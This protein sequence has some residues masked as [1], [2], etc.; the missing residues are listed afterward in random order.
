[1]WTWRRFEGDGFAMRHG[2]HSDAPAQIACPYSSVALK[3]MVDSADGTQLALCLCQTANRA[4]P[5]HCPFLTAAMQNPVRSLSPQK[6]RGSSMGRDGIAL[7]VCLCS[8]APVDFLCRSVSCCR[9]FNTFERR[10]G[11]TCG[12]FLANS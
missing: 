12:L 7:L 5:G 1:M 4:I 11:H 10:L 8:S 2:V 6:S 3:E 9:S